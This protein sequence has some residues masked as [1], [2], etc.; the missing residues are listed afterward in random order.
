MSSAS[1]AA[2]SALACAGGEAEALS[3]STGFLS[4]AEAVRGRAAAS[5]IASASA[6]QEVAALRSRTAALEA[7]LIVGEAALRGAEALA[8]SYALET[9]AA[10]AR[11][12][13]LRVRL[14]EAAESAE[15]EVLEHESLRVAAARLTAENAELRGRISAIATEQAALQATASSAR[16]TLAEMAEER[17][18]EVGER[19][20]F[21]LPQ[22][23]LRGTLASLS[24][25]DRRALAAASRALCGLVTAALASSI[26]AR[27]GGEAGAMA[28]RTSDSSSAARAGSVADEGPLSPVSQARAVSTIA[29]TVPRNQSAR[30]STGGSMPTDTA[31]LAAAGF[32][33]QMA[34]SGAHYSARFDT[35]AAPVTSASSNAVV[36]LQ[37]LVAPVGELSERGASATRGSSGA[38]FDDADAFPQA[39]AGSPQPPPAVSQ[40]KPLRRSGLFGSMF[41]TGSSRMG[42]AGRETVTTP[43]RAVG[44]GGGAGVSG[45]AASEAATGSAVGRLDYNDAYALL[46]KVKQAEA[47]V[48][49]WRLQVQDLVEKLHTTETV[50]D[51][52]RKRLDEAETT[53]REAVA[54]HEA[55]RA[56][57]TIDQET[58][59]FL[60]E[61]LQE[62][63]AD[64]AASAA[65]TERERSRAA[66]AEAAA[67][68]LRDK[69]SELQR[70]L[71]AA[72]AASAAV[73]AQT[74]IP[75]PAPVSAPAVEPVGSAGAG[76]GADS[77]ARA[78]L[79]A[80]VAT[81][82]RDELVE[83][84]RRMAATHDMELATLRKEKAVLV[85]AV[86]AARAREAA[87]P[88]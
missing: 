64:A 9:S 32:Q 17:A 56:Q 48:T 2:L 31:M 21:R 42:E 73:A 11:T 70:A 71:A 36:T 3:L 66:E 86:K 8:A 54:A 85:Q 13:S 7:A 40:R 4:I 77:F 10:T 19:L 67:A 83:A 63:Q 14:A 5:A 37:G 75:V 80:D 51:F 26:T 87:M 20:F 38:G 76:I 1:D 29:S 53:A 25:A 45:A 28:R 61:R 24:A 74:L 65:A 55:A 72:S 84:M 23:A 41:S 58:L 60:D 15:A 50:R 30:A 43:Q 79:P 34:A 47:A 52:L 81:L 57:Q 16:K 82:S 69:V 88:A 49:A 35:A 44:G 39:P 46:G 22:R 78:G 12:Q 59:S 62:V 68:L 33:A 18:S 6:S 27:G